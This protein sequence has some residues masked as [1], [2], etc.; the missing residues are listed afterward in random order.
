MSVVEMLL[1]RRGIGSLIRLALEGDPI[2]LTIIGALVLGIVV[3]VGVQIYNA[4]ITP[5]SDLS[6]DDLTAEEKGLMNRFD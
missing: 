5:E 4:V 1:A 3:F 2:A 6:D